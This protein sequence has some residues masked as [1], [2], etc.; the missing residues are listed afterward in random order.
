MAVF[1][2]ANL[3]HLMEQLRGIMGSVALK[4]EVNIISVDF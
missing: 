3:L 4:S 2:L 1:Q